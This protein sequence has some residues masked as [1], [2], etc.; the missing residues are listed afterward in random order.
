MGLELNVE[1]RTQDNCKTKHQKRLPGE[2]GFLTPF[3][4]WLV[5]LNQCTPNGPLAQLVGRET[6]QGGHM[7]SFDQLH[8]LSQYGHSARTEERVSYP[9][10]PVKL[11]EL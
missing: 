6:C 8:G 3:L 9:T 1:L 2:P 4:G 5:C 7:T 10:Y 11:G